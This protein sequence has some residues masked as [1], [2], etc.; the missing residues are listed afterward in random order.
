M[1]RKQA[2]SGRMFIRYGAQMYAFAFGSMLGQCAA[3]WEGGS[4]FLCLR[5]LLS[6]AAGKEDGK[7]LARG[8]SLCRAASI[9]VCFAL[10]VLFFCIVAAAV[11]GV[12][13]LVTSLSMAVG[14]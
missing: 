14:Q 5:S 13:V 6:I 7:R 3:H 8:Q 4:L 11:G 9:G 1:D 10:S 12:L 2:P